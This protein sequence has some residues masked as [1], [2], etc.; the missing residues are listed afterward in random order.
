M[1]IQYTHLT[2]EDRCQIYALYKGGF[3]QS[4]IARELGVARCTITREF[5]RNTGKRGYRVH[6]AQQMSETRRHKASTCSRKKIQGE[7]QEWVE[8][9][10][11]EK[12]SPEQTSGW[13]ENNT[14]YTLSHETIYQH[15]R[16][17]KKA[18]GGL[19]LHLRHRG[20]K[21]NK[22]RVSAD[23][24]EAGRGLIP[25]RKDI[26]ER[27]SIVDKKSRIGDW[28]ADLIIGANHKGAILSLVE[29][30]SKFTKLALLQGKTAE[31]VNAAIKRILSIYKAY[32]KTITFDN[33]KEFARHGDCAAFLGA[34][35]YFARPYHSWERGLNEHTN[36]LVRQYFPKGTYFDTITCEEVQF[37]EDALNHRPRKI[38]NFK[39][40][41][42]VFTEFVNNVALRP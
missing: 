23:G 33:G 29:R 39:M 2:F 22:R 17:D 6:Q 14:S 13:I 40:P 3:S 25:N 36:G 4:R 9:K 37:V 11:Q 7:L 20:K 19:F 24:K 27:P 12:W 28:E 31:E 32:V 38:L 10:I 42:T 21:Y 41:H 30:R 5:Q 35:C 15:I 18:G 34:A 8:S 1:S 16:E 26:S